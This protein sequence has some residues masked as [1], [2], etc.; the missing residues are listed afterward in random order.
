MKISEFL[1]NR[2]LFLLLTSTTLVVSSQRIYGQSWQISSSLYQKFSK[3]TIYIES[4]YNKTGFLKTSIDTLK[5]TGFLISD[6]GKIYLVTARQFLQSTVLGENKGF[7]NDTLSF[8]GSL[9]PKAKL[10][11]FG[12]MN[13]ASSNKGSIAFDQ[14]LDGFI[15]L[16]LQDKRFRPL[17]K[18]LLADGCV[19]LQLAIFDTTTALQK[20]Q[21][22][23]LS[24][25]LNY[26]DSFGFKARM[27]G[28][29]PGTTTSI[30]H[31]SFFRIN[32][33]IQPGSSGSPVFFKEK[34]LGMILHGDE[35]TSNAEALKYPYKQS[36]SATC[37]RAKNILTALRMLQEKERV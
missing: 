9:N 13:S 29:S 17:L 16:S 22:V 21:Q 3:S 12:G 8:T 15:V 37:I 34:L 35:V 6:K 36:K 26:K 31:S 32:S 10:F 25:F 14:D 11:R 27:H 18:R 1:F 4:A 5:G 30:G 2:L 33:T 7:L 23:M 20:S 19:P 28:I 24:F